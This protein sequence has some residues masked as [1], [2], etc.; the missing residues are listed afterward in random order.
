MRV[1]RDLPG[2][3]DFRGFEGMVGAPDLG[4]RANRDACTT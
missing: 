2:S 3:A 4:Y 1:A